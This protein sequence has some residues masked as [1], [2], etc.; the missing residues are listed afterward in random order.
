MPTL[1]S[2]PITVMEDNQ[3][4]IKIAKNKFSSKSTRHIDAKNHVVRDATDRGKLAIVYVKT[5]S[6]HAD[7]L[8]K[9]LEKN[10]FEEHN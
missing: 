6:Q 8:T 10:K 9:A 2:Y 4:A 3:G 1:E 7:V 5:G